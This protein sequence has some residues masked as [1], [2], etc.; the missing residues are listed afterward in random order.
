MLPPFLVSHQKNGGSG[1]EGKG[2]WE[3]SKKKRLWPKCIDCERRIKKKEKQLDLVS[4]L[5]IFHMAV[6][7]YLKYGNKHLEQ[8]LTFA[9]SSRLQCI[10][11]AGSWSSHQKAKSNELINASTVQDP[12][13]PRNF[14]T[15]ILD[16]S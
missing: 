1:E 7:K 16:G 15:H 10:M 3:E 9:Q 2:F 8:G 13:K 6:T 12:T 14:A 5:F 4:I 11:W